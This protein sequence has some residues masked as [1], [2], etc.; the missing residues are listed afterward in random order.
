MNF[1]SSLIL[2]F[3]LSLFTLGACNQK[4]ASPSL[5]NPN[6]GIPDD[7]GTLFQGGDGQKEPG[8]K[9]SVNKGG[10]QDKGGDKG[11]NN[12]G[13]NHGGGSNGGPGAVPEPAT[14]LLLGSGLAGAAMARRRKRKGLEIQEGE[15]EI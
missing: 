10:S 11:G 12:G 1:K 7:D 8:E 2:V 13:G 6:I 4:G 9:H 5:G 14:L 15:G 3:S